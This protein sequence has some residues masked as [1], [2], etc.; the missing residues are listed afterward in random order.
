MN[1]A[2]EHREEGEEQQTQQILKTLDVGVVIY[3]GVNLLDVTNIHK[4]I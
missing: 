2:I 3:N 1:I 4:K